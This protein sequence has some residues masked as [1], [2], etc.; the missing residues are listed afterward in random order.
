MRPFMQKVRENEVER[1]MNG[2]M[3][4]LEKLAWSQQVSASVVSG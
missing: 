3:T 4:K 1:A 2:F